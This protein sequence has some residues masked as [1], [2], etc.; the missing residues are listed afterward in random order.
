MKLL[1]KK[2]FKDSLCI[3]PA[4]KGSKGIKNKNIIK[5]LGKPLIQ[6]TFDVAKKIENNFDILVST[7]SD[8]IKK[9][10]I[11]NNFYF[12]GK[13]PKSL[14]SDKAETKDVLKF[15]L[16]RFEKLKN[17]KY[18]HILLLQATC[19]YRNIKK[20]NFSLKKIKSKLYD[21][22]VSVAKVEAEH[23]L[24]MKIFKSKYLKNYI[25]KN[26]ENMKPRQSL[27]K[28]Y[29]R[30]GSIYLF[31]RDVLMKSNSIVGK[32]CYGLIL[33]GK[34]TINIDTKEQLNYL[35][36]KYKKKI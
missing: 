1:L 32:K 35:R 3:I 26:K 36:L 28:V 4:R 5:F 17:K 12:I 8:K 33:K 13:R 23:P 6:H 30:S 31:N 10:A 14:S 22:V 21:S 9:L 25:K 27:P 19:P 7:D 15:E 18:K 20:I 16:K 29:L 2:K 24:R 11:K 34:E